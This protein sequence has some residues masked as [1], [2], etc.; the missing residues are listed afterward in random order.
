MRTLPP[1][2]AAAWP[3]H[4][5]ESSAPGSTYAKWKRGAGRTSYS[6]ATSAPAP[7]TRPSPAPRR[8]APSASTACACSS[9]CRSLIAPAPR[10]SPA[11]GRSR[12]GAARGEARCR[13]RN[14][15]HRGAEKARRPA[16]RV[17]RHRAQAAGGGGAGR[18]GRA[19]PG[20]R[21]ARGCDRRR[22]AHHAARRGA[23]GGVEIDP[24][25][26]APRATNVLLTPDGPYPFS[27]GGVSTWCDTLIRNTPEVRYTLLPLMMNPHVELKYTPPANVR[28]VL[29]V[30]MWGIEEP[31]EFLTDIPFAS[32]YE[33]KQRTPAAA[34]ENEFLPAFRAFLDA[35]L[36]D[37]LSAL[38]SR[39]SASTSPQR[40]TAESRSEERRV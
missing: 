37:G 12:C 3:P 38:S 35:I 19:A 6:P 20:I 36:D 15:P 9:R 17:G 32:L 13:G 23:G 14:A 26:A 7:R 28:R 24:A 34:I 30:P 1:S 33:R 11:R 16:R 40:P 2:T 31:A 21:R 25:A 5:R 10:T 27:G 29:E 22:R 8:A 39:L 18:G 4:S